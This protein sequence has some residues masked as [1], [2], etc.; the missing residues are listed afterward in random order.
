MLMPISENISLLI[1]LYKGEQNWTNSS[2]RV[3]STSL[4]PLEGMVIEVQNLISD[5]EYTNI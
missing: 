5:W 1:K 3:L 4:Y 2:V